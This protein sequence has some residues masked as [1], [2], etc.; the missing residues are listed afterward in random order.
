VVAAVAVVGS[1]ATPAAA[2]VNEVPTPTRAVRSLSLGTKHTCVLFDNGKVGCWGRNGE[3]QMGVGT[4]ADVGD[5]PGEMGSALRF[6]DLGTGRTATAIAAGS[7]H[8]CALLDTG[9]V[10]CW[11]LGAGG[12]LGQ[13]SIAPIGAAPGQMGD[14]LAPIDLGT[15][16]T[17]VALT[18]GA[19]HTCAILDTRQV[20]CW[21][22]NISGQLGAGELDLFG[23]GPGEMGDARP[24]VDLGTGRTARSISAGASHTCAVLDTNQL[25]CWGSATFGQLGLGSEDSI[26]DGP[27]EMGDSLDPVDLGT[28]RTA[29]AVSAGRFHTCV[30][31]D[32]AQVKCWGRGLYGPLGSGG[33]DDIGDDPGEMGDSLDP[34]DLG[35][36][37][38]ARSISAGDIH[39]CAIL[40]T[41]QVKCW[42]ANVWGQIGT[43]DLF[44]R[45]DDPGEMGDALPAVDLGASRTPLA[46]TT[47]NEHTCAVLTNRRVVCWG[48]NDTGHLGRGDTVDWGNTAGQMGDALA[49]ISLPGTVG[50]GLQRPDNAVRVG[51]ASFVGNDV[52]NTTGRRQTVRTQVTR[53]VTRVITVRV[54]NDGNEPDRFTVRGTKADKRFA[55]TY[56]QG[57]RNLTRA[58]TRG[59]FVTPVL[60]PGASLDLRVTVAPK[61]AARP[62]ARLTATVTTTSRIDTA[63][64]DVVRAL[65]VHR[66]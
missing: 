20:K 29:R 44:G 8:T 50:L 35:T 18:A 46:V 64:R 45:G 15:G 13:G 38:T 12:Q 4:T 36:G 49:Y 48:R 43:G 33:N 65:I 54:Q 58:V 39:T 60:Q 52:R 51:R 41:R 40:D 61:K 57:T 22:S 27:G 53:G 10:K 7:Y 14:A 66:R 37:R 59:R 62:G 55:V 9:Q 11:G 19:S 25:K 24:T 26:G 6:V 32:T 63:R 56:R 47:E 42:G 28:G 1:G 21:G 5:D 23:D 17:A 30:L 16:R 34:V 2:D 3:G 31:L